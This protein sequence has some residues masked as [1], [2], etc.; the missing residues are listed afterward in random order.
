MRL[1]KYVSERFFSS[2]TKAARAIAEGRVT[3]NGRVAKASDEVREGDDV[4][5][6]TAFGRICIG[7]RGKSSRGR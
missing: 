4:R 1:D 6:E 7:R 5:L 2:R 3:L